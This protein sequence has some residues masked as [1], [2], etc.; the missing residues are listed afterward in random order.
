MKS[1]EEFTTN[2]KRLSF[3]QHQDGFYN[4][5][6][7]NQLTN[8][9]KILESSSINENYDSYKKRVLKHLVLLE[10]YIVDSVISCLNDIFKRKFFKSKF[11]KIEG[12]NFSFL[13]HCPD[14]GSIL[15]FYI[16][17]DLVASENTTLKDAIHQLTIRVSSE[18]LYSYI[19][20]S[21]DRNVK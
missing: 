15:N 4:C 12:G 16:N 11:Y 10:E 14:T 5:T 17:A 18:Y 7:K 9:S 19:K 13:I 1:I 20:N 21:V 6:V 3:L 2:I 8:D